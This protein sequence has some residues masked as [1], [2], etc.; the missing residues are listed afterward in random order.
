MEIKLCLRN[1][2]FKF[3]GGE[4][5][6]FLFRMSVMNPSILHKHIKKIPKLS[7]RGSE[8]AEVIS[9]F[10]RCWITQFGLSLKSKNRKFLKINYK[11][12]F[13]ILL[14]FVRFS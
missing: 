4:L 5:T 13:K 12:V 10:R 6:I 2:H 8:A 11:A 7:F 3:K 1:H 9:L 14:E